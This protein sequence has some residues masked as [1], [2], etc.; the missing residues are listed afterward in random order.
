VKIPGVKG[1]IIHLSNKLGEKVDLHRESVKEINTPRNLITLEEFLYDDEFWEKIH[2]DGSDIP[3]DFFDTDAK[4]PFEYNPLNVVVGHDREK[5]RVVEA[6]ENYLREERRREELEKEYK[7]RGLPEDAPGKVCIVDKLKEEIP[8]VEPIF[9]FGPYGSSKSLQQRCYQKLF[10]MLREKFGVRGH[11]YVAEWDKTKPYGM[12]IHTHFGGDEIARIENFEKREKRKERIKKVLKLSA[13]GGGGCIASYWIVRVFERAWPYFYQMYVVQ[14][15]D[16]WGFVKRLFDILEATIWIQLPN[17]APLG[18]LALGAAGLALISKYL[19]RHEDRK[20]NL[21]ADARTIPPVLLGHESKEE[22][23]GK[24]LDEEGLAPQFKITPSLLLKA[25]SKPLIVE[26][27][28]NLKDDVQL[29]LAQVMEEREIEVAGRF[30]RFVRPLFL[31]GANTE[32]LPGV[33]DPLKNRIIYGIVEEVTNEIERNKKNER[34]LKAF[35]AFLCKKYGTLFAD[36]DAEN[37][38]IEICSRLADDIGK[39]HISRRTVA[40]PRYAGRFAEEEGCKYISPKHL[41][42]AEREVKS[43]VQQVLERRLKH[44][45]DRSNVELEGER[46]G[47]VNVV[48]LAK[49]SEL[50]F[51]SGLEDNRLFEKDVYLGAQSEDHIGYIG[52]IVANVFPV[53]DFRKA[54]FEIIDEKGNLKNKDFYKNRI[55]TLLRNDG[56]DISNDIVMLD[57]RLYN[58]DDVIVTGGYLAIRSAKRKEK[59][60]QDIALAV[61]LLPEGVTTPVD[62]LNARLYGV[63]EQI[64]SVIVTSYDLEK[65]IKKE[66]YPRM[67]F[68]VANNK[69]EII[70]KI[71]KDYGEY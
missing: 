32:K 9:F 21:L 43:I 55:E 58:D 34:H 63:H 41:K 71:F 35:L 24:Y 46:I 29:I 67:K 26:N 6:I 12:D 7:R 54:K 66:W 62:K 42:M 28:P 60:K 5:K 15:G 3:L 31:F 47:K 2:R 36:L 68:E 37:E 59:I 10:F 16:W 70:R 48:G 4:P 65:R 13:I 25:D 39:L 11:G 19:K 22:L 53:D 40:I 69:D 1:I 57:V 17:Y 14:Q 18:Y 20:P 30:R 50:G 52:T 44:Y 27:L 51:T 64:D 38:Y 33:V 56:I 49:E 8:P 45:V 61:G 23:I